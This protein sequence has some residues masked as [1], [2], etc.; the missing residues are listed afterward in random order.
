[1]TTCAMDEYLGAYV[2]GALDRDQEAAVI[3]HLPGCARCAEE[4]ADLAETVARMALL[5][6]HDVEQALAADSGSRPSGPCASPAASPGGRGRLPVRRAVLTVLGALVV[7]GTAAGATTVVAGERQ[8]AVTITAS[9][10]ASDTGATLTVARRDAATTLH[11]S[12]RG[13][14]PGETCS[15]VVHSR[16][17]R[18][19]TV[20]TWPAGPDGTSDVH[21]V[22]TLPPD[23][24]DHLDVVT[25]SGHRLVR[26]LMPL[27]GN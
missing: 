27:L 14:Y 24:V 16:D 12:L 3:S 10:Q 17:G 21:A 4:M 23:D 9:D 15:L 13:V 1:M 11:L 7:A 26:L 2:L 20:A 25:T 6:R 5:S 19:E 22:T 18:A 8:P